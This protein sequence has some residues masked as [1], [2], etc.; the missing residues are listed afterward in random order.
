MLDI[1]WK[2]L[3]AAYIQNA[4]IP[5]PIVPIPSLAGQPMNSH[6][7]APTLKLQAPETR[8]SISAIGPTIAIFGRVVIGCLTHCSFG[9]E[10][11]D[12]HC[13][14]YYNFLFKLQ[15]LINIK[16]K[17]P[18]R[19]LFIMDGFLLNNQS[20]S[21]HLTSFSQFKPV[22]SNG[23]FIKTQFNLSCIQFRHVILY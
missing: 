9:Q 22:Q 6:V 21:F 17:P 23:W 15:T 1:S 8:S 7:L 10:F 18:K 2:L 13:S 16:K 3:A 20:L 11:R 5:I 12:D 14:E 19:R 4:L